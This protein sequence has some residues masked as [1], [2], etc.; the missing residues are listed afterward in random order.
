MI[1]FVDAATRFPTAILTALLVAMLAYWLLAAIGL[2]DVEDS[3]LGLDMD[4]DVDGLDVGT[5]ASYLV[6]FGLSGVPISVVVSLILLVSWTLCCLAAMWLIP[7]IPGAWLETAAG[8][9]ALMA[10]IAV[11]LPITAVALRPLRGLFVTHGARSNAS[12]VGESCKVLSQTVDETFGRAEVNTRGA[13]LNIKVWAHVP[14]ALARGS[15][16]RIL[17]YDAGKGGYLIAAD[18]VTAD[19]L[20][21]PTD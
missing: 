21:H 12:L 19:H 7:L 9:G 2:V 16:A 6:A 20:T 8:A 17:D 4:M 10:S 11:S 14:N 3:G 1:D 18:A 13:S 5:V 15:T